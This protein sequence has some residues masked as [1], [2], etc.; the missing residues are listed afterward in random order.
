MNEIGLALPSRSTV[1]RPGLIVSPATPVGATTIPGRLLYLLALA[2]ISK[3]VVMAVPGDGVGCGCV[4]ACGKG[5]Q[6]LLHRLALLDAL[7]AG[8]ILNL[9]YGHASPRLFY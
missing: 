7:D 8:A 3:V 4:S 5:C 1:P 6:E 2:E 9:R